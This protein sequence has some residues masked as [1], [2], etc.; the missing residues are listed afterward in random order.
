MTE[1]YKHTPLQ[2][3]GSIRLLELLPSSARDA[4]L[5]CKI[6]EIRLKKAR[7]QYEALSYVWGG[8]QGSEP[9]LCD[10]QELLVTPNCRDALI[11][12]RRRY[13]KRTLWID[14][15]CIDQTPEGELERNHQVKVMGQVY[16]N[17]STV[18]IWLGLE[19]LPLTVKDHLSIWG[20]QLANYLV[21]FPLIRFHMLM[22]KGKEDQI[23]EQLQA[24]W[25]T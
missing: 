2:S 10:G 1:R 16:N 15:I 11:T 13:F 4:P 24:K 9:I 3:P 25:G 12:L 23:G 8:K 17:A 21:H 20:P 7:S 5:T 6:R 22:G 18:L 14:A 19:E